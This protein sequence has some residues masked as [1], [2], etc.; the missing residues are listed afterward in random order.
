[1]IKK[2]ASSD[3]KYSH[4]RMK[5]KIRITKKKKSGLTLRL[6]LLQA[7]EFVPFHFVKPHFDECRGFLEFR[8]NRESEV[9]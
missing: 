2:M 3:N 8:N 5:V 4:C 1:M 9:R 6:D 7:N